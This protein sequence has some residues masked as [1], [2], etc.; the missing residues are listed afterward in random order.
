MGLRYRAAHSIVCL[1]LSM[2]QA[3]WAC[4]E[5][6]IEKDA[7]LCREHFQW[8]CSKHKKTQ[9]EMLKGHRTKAVRRKNGR[10]IE[11]S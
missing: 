5:L 9:S 10:K 1:K 4:E 11:Y 3:Y 8:N 2:V 7:F 6:I